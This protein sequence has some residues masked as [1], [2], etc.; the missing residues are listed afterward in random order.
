MK[1]QLLHILFP[2]LLHFICLQFADGQ[3]SKAGDG[4]GF[5]SR[6]NAPIEMDVQKSDDRVS[7]NAFNKSFYPYDITVTFSDLQNLLPKVF[8]RKMV[9]FPG[10]NTLFVLNVVNKDQSIQYE[11]S[12]SY[13]IKISDNPD[14]SF[15]YL[16]P[17]SAGKT[18]KFQPIN[19]SDNKT[20]LNNNFLMLEKDTVFAIRKGIVTAL[21]DNSKEVDRIIKSTSLEIYHNDGTIAIYLGLDPSLLL[22]Q[23]GQTVYPRQPIGLIGPTHCLILNLLAKNDNA[24]LKGVEIHFVNETGGII[25]ALSVNGQKVGF[26]KEIIKKEMTDK[27]ARKYDKGKLY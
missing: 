22:I 18:V 5:S 2:F 10:N 27:E 9:I 15:P 14:L 11:Y 16:F 17:L 1:N 8:E 6:L 23:L 12:I 7:F 21:P 24:T 13:K 25:S 20:F 4:F 19:S 26:S 3:Y